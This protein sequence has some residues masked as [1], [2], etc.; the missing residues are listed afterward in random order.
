MGFL[1]RILQATTTECDPLC[2]MA[3][4]AVFSS[5]KDS[6]CSII[7][8]KGTMHGST[9]LSIRLT[10]DNLQHDKAN[11]NYGNSRQNSPS[12]LC[13]LC[14]REMSQRQR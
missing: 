13:F 14:S 11:I 6:I 7:P 4:L 12:E 9:S 8:K 3:C 1:E 2:T 10:F 5:I